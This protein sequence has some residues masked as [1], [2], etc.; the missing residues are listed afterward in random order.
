MTNI[1]DANNLIYSYP[2]PVDE[3]G[4]IAEEKHAL[5][6]VSLTVEK[7]SFVAILG[8]NGSGKSTFAKHINV[9]L[10]AQ[11]GT[12]FVVGMDAN[13]EKNTWDIRSHAGM[14]FQNPDNQIVSTIVEEDVAFGPENLGVPREEIIRRV[15]ESLKAVGMAG[16]E[17]R[18]PHMLSGGQKQR[19]A[20]AGV[21]AMHPDIIVF[22]EP[23]AMLDPKGRDE[24][25]DSIRYLN[26]EQGKTIVLIT[27]YM[28]EA[29]EADRV[30]IMNSGKITDEGTPR[31]VFSHKDKLAEAGLLPPLATQVYQELLEQGMDLGKCPVTLTELVEELCRL[32]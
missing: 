12:L 6:G 24:V 15:H 13:D 14:V 26:R 18:A 25:M 11:E 27:H 1:I 3:E 30:F 28:E 7:G 10:R 21:L 19:I 20:I 9:L 16:F 5:D 2:A 23:T 17:K 29:A 8:H 4:N 32:Q 22:D 31:E